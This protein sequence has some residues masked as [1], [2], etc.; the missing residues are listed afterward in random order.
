M[1]SPLTS[2][3]PYSGCGTRRLLRDGCLR[4]SVYDPQSSHQLVALALNKSS[5]CIVGKVTMAFPLILSMPYFES[6][7]LN[8]CFIYLTL[9]KMLDI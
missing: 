2:S 6:H 3:T 4:Y 7:I 9:E 5:L 8:N 1:T